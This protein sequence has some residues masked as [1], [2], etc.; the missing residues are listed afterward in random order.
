MNLNNITLKTQEILQSAQ[1]LAQQYQH[2][3][4]EPE[5]LFKA[6]LEIDKDMIPY[7]FKKLQL[8]KDLL[9]KSMEKKLVALPKVQG[10]Q[11][12]FSQKASQCV[13]EA[14]KLAQENGDDFVATQHLLEALFIVN[15][16]VSQLLKDLGLKTK[17]LKSAI[18]DLRKGEKV[19]SASAESSYNALQKYARNLNKMAGEGKLDPVIGRDEEIRRLLQI[20]SRRTKSIWFR[21]GSS[22]RRSEI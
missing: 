17:N 16:N 11:H 3:Q 1:L 10:G 22:Y 13:L 14:Q 20:L 6:L 2:Q 4:I 15:S 8:N 21:Y 5:H 7:L 18:Y 12:M 9:E 19:N